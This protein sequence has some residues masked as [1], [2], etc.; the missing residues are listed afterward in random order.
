MPSLTHCR[1]HAVL[2]RYMR[3]AEASPNF[4]F[5]AHVNPFMCALVC[6]REC[7][8][9]DTL[10]RP[11]S[12]L[13][14]LEG[15]QV[16]ATAVQLVAVGTVQCVQCEA[17]WGKGHACASPQT[18]CRPEHTSVRDAGAA[19]SELLPMGHF[20]PFCLREALKVLGRCLLI[21]RAPCRLPSAAS[22]ASPASR[23]GK[24]GRRRGRRAG[25]AAAAR[26]RGGGG[27]AAAR[28]TNARFRHAHRLLACWLHLVRR[29]RAAGL[30]RMFCNQQMHSMQLSASQTRVVLPGGY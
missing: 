6:S 23:A 7:L 8:R 30:L 12:G 27:E 15:G 26:R 4:R 5:N 3:L 14:A 24:P 22:G 13:P 21:S 17:A 19:F 20:W 2:F 25:T 10:E 16:E 1:C 28:R 18:V 9:H 29:W 11:G